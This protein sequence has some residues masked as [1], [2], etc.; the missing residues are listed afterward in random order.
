MKPEANEQLM[1]EILD[2]HVTFYIDRDNRLQVY[3]EYPCYNGAVAMEPVSSEVFLAFLGHQYRQESDEMI[4][5]DY[6]ELIAIKIQ[7]MRYRQENPVQ[8]H[9][10]VAGS[11]SKGKIAY[12]LADDRWTTVLISPNSI[13]K[14][15]SK[16]MK[17]LKRSMSGSHPSIRRDPTKVFRIELYGLLKRKKQHDAT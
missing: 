17:F 6:S 14:G 9:R 10:R 5:P 7:N 1:R 15:R 8:I 4:M 2:D 3:V 16:K 13:K 12:F 11:I